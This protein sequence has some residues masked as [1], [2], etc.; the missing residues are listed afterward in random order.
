MMKDDEVI[1]TAKSRRGK[2]PGAKPLHG[3]QKLTDSVVKAMKLPPTGAPPYE[4]RDTEVTGLS[5]LVSYGGTKSWW[6]NYTYPRKSK[7]RRRWGLGTFSESRAAD[8]AGKSGNAKVEDARRRARHAWDSL[9]LGV[10]PAAAV[11]EAQAQLE[12]PV[13][14]TF[15]ALAERY[16]S[17]KAR[18]ELRERTWREYERQIGK[19]LLPAW[20]KLAAQDVTKAM[21]HEVLDVLKTNGKGV[22]ANRL[23]ATASAI[24]NFGVD[25]SV[26]ASNPCSGIG[27]AKEKAKTRVLSNDEIRKLWLATEDPIIRLLMLTGQRSGEVTGMLWREIDLD[28][29]TWSMPGE[30][31]KN[32][33]P[34]SIPL[35]GKALDIVSAQARRSDGRV[36]GTSPRREFVRARVASGIE[37]NFS[38]H[39]LRRTFGTKLADLGVLETVYRK[40][41]NHSDS[42]NI[43]A[44]VYIQHAFD[45]EKREA[46][47]RWD[48]ELARIVSGQKADVI[49]IKSARA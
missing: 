31:T 49:D 6:L 18:P 36:F 23:Q 24:M 41:L 8:D 28:A 29:K 14:T 1:E 15:A 40:L 43:T 33:L 34:H 7:K 39:D 38:V 4:V 25:K 32:G 37:E 17:Q 45:K 3:R 10:D 35:V 22:Q 48:R 16:L 13:A 27:L 46:L 30:R 5:V 12:A 19:Y 42:K 2:A 44:R 26:L 11:R 21:V 9:Q 20:G 47:T